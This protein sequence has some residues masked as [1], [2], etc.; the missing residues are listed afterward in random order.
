MKNAT[1]NLISTALT[2]SEKAMAPHSSTLAWRIPWMVEPGRL[3]SMGSLRVR[4][5]WATSLSL[6]TFMHWRRKWQS[7]WGAWWAAVCGVA[8][9]RTRLKQPS[10]S[11]RSSKVV[12]GFPGSSDGKESACNVGDLRSMPG[13]G[14]PP[15]E[16]NG[17]PLQYSCLQK[18]MDRGAW[19]ATVRGVAKSQIPLSN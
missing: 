7:T 10:S 13:L 19:R 8:Q 3:Q 5:Y 16:G 4:H 1:G 18:S 2:L 14:R 15:G 12:M 9:S 17:N 6:F 11:S